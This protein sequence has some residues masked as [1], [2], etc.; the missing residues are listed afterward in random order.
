MQWNWQTVVIGFAFLAFLLFAKYIVS[1]LIF[2]PD[3]FALIIYFGET[4]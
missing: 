2:F 3:N 1:I 4:V